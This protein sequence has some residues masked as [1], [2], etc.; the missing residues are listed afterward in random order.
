VDVLPQKYT[1]DHL[2]KERAF[3]VVHEDCPT[4]VS[5]YCFAGANWSLVGKQDFLITNEVF[6]QC[7]V[8]YDVHHCMTTNQQ[9]L[10]DV[11]VRACSV[12]DGG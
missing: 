2:N 11:V 1:L 8:V 9:S 5:S 3:P 7:A 6:L 4:N 12:K 10:F